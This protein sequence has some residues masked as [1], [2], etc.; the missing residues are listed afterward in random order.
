MFK[1]KV[2]HARVGSWCCLALLWAIMLLLM[3]CNIVI[4]APASAPAGEGAAPAAPAEKITVVYWAHD[5]TPRV[6]LDKK[7]IAEFM[8]ANPDIE[9]QYEVIPA[10][11]DAK[12]RTALAAGTGPDLFAQWNGDIGQ[13]YAEEA[14]VPVDFTAMGLN[15]QQEFMDLYV[16]PDNTLQGAIF[17]GKL[18]GIPNEL[19]IYACYA[20]KKMFEEAGLDAETDFPTTWEDMVIVAE[21]LTKRDA[22]GTLVQRG[23]DFA[24]G[25]SV[26][27]F[28][29]WGA[30]VRQL[31]GSEL[32]LTTPEA[33][34]AMQYW[35][36]WVHKYQ[37]GGPAYWG[38]QLDDFLAGKVAI[39]CDL[40]SWA[41]PQIEEA[42]IEYT[43]KPVP[44]WANAKN[45]NHFDI[46]AYF[47]MVNARSAPEV[48][49]AAWKLAG[50]LD[51]HP[52]EY[53]VSTGLLQARKE[54]VESKE[55]QDTPYINVFLDEMT[56]S[57]YSPRIPRFIEVADVL[58]RARDRVVVEGMDIKESLAMGQ[59]E[60]DEILAEQPME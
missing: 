22:D 28:L 29:Q 31:G 27:M 37:L 34:Q 32:E 15:S 57:M 8:E 18:Y 33:E 13:F 56:V 38:A 19:S 59:Q 40:G 9:V 41:R 60:I 3:S 46:Y 2:W 11:F 10:D 5:F 1:F 45:K 55:Y 6:E 30:M 49:R 17:E 39:E 53:M 21:K 48:Q 35:V 26:W 7:Y 14:I 23:F 16:A 51:S 54:L 20:N 36:D 24:W 25:G 58:A 12:L 4:P 50:F 52:I 47:H 43:V 44:I 42:N